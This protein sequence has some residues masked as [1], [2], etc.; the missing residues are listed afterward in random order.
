MTIGTSRAIAGGTAILLIAIGAFLYY[1][2]HGTQSEIA[3]FTTCKAAGYQVVMGDGRITHD[4]C[5][6]PDGEVFV[7]DAA[8]TPDTATTTASST[9]SMI[10][11]SDLTANQLVKSP[12]TV[13]G[14]ALGNWFF[15]A[16][17]PV[18]LLDGNG[19]SLLMVPAQAQGD[20]MTS[21][22]VPFSVTLSFAQP[23]T[24][25]GTLVFRNDN[26]SGL[27]ENQKELRIPLRFK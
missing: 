2:K 25:T 7:S 17:F 27:P 1:S 23:I 3:D 6:T 24:A 4:S 26:P 9:E 19:K 10:R 14:Q 12:L 22:F 5:S 16:S 15:E 13:T 11:I 21:S 8:L 18:E 20:W